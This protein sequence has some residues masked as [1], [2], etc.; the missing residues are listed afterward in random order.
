MVIFFP[1]PLISAGVWRSTAT[2]GGW[3]YIPAI[4]C[5]ANFRRNISWPGARNVAHENIFR[6]LPC[7]SLILHITP[8]W[9]PPS[10]IILWALGSK[11]KCDLNFFVNF[12]F[13]KWPPYNGPSPII[14]PFGSFWP[15]ARAQWRG[16]VWTFLSNKTRNK[17]PLEAF[18]CGL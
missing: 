11:R 18:F 16:G 1:L 15:E 9:C 12:F 7:C 8:P 5:F 4:L 13:G 2:R 3:P 6:W 10:T 17:S 14:G